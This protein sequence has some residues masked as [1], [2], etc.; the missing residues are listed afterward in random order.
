MKVRDLKDFFNSQHISRNKFAKLYPKVPASTLGYWFEEKVEEDSEVT[1]YAIVD[2]IN[3]YLTKHGG[4]GYVKENK[5]PSGHRVPIYDLEAYAGSPEYSGDLTQV[6]Q[7]GYIETSYL[8]DIDGWIRVKGDSMY[9]AYIQGEEIGLKRVNIEQI[10]FGS[11]YV[12]VFGGDFPHP[13][14]LK[15]LRKSND[16]DKLILRSHNEKYED[17]EIAKDQIAQIFIVR[18]RIGDVA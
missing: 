6:S 7:L 5:L 4:N 3:D 9:P 13:P 16:P 11:P 2:A 1:N 15:Y 17:M 12:V 14:V 8:I 18:K 10:S